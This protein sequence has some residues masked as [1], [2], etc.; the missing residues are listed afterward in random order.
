MAHDLEDVLAVEAS[1]SGQATGEAT[2]VL[3]SLPGGI[4]RRLPLR[5]RHPARWGGLLALLGIA[6]A[7]VLW[8][9]ASGAHRG[10]GTSQGAEARGG[11]VPVQLSQT[12][13]HDYN[14]FGTG[15][16]NRD[17]VQNLID[18]DPNTTWS[19]EQYYD[20]TL[21][22]PGGTGL[23]VYLDAAPRVRAR[24]IEIQTPTPGFAVQVYAAQRVELNVPY[25]DSTSLAARGWQGPVGSDA[26]VRSGARIPVS[27]SRGYRYYLV[28]MTTLPPGQESA[29]LSELTLFR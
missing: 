1:R 4:R 8:L 18:G 22:K 2:T 21:R 28:W 20:G 10:V 25:G 27:V 9:A 15:P 7:L 3:R 11:L 17:Q 6:T 13:A 26:S 12:A 14:P 29:T 24:A 23:G 5:L 16:E 19:T